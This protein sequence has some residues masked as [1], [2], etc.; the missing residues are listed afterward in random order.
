MSLDIGEALRD[1]FD[2][3]RA[4]SGL[5]LVGVFVA[6]GLVNTVVQESLVRVSVGGLLDDLSANPPS[7]EGSDLTAAEFQDLLTEVRESIA[8]GTPLA[9]LDSLSVLELAVAAVVLAVLAEAIR[10]IAI[11]VFVS[12]ET[13]SIPRELVTRNL[14]WAVLNGVIGGIVAGILVVVGFVLL[15]I[16]G[17]FLAVSFLFLRQEIAIEDRNFIE[18]LSGSWNLASGSRIELFVLVVILVLVGPVVSFVVGLVGSSAPVALLNVIATSVVLTY[19]VAVVSEAY[20]Q[21]R[22][23]DQGP[24]EDTP[25]G[26]DDEFTGIDDELL[27]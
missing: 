15:V 19:T 6:F 5:A 16:P 26:G 13:G 3:V 21:L 22:M 4:S 24:V 18:A 17:V 7:V 12:P 2:G 27:P 9:Y 10:M 11:R 23:E 1:G 8:E 20:D 14:V 25:D